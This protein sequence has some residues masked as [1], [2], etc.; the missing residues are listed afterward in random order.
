M[1]IKISRGF[2]IFLSTRFSHFI[3]DKKLNEN[4]KQQENNVKTDITICIRTLKGTLFNDIS[5]E[6]LLVL[7]IGIITREL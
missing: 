3:S 6:D 5:Y 2:I 4:D 7:Y 1:Q